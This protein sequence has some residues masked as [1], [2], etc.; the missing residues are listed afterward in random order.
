MATA[1][2]HEQLVLEIFVRDIQ[3]SSAFYRALGFE[4]VRD[5]GAFVELAFDGCLLFLEERRELP[6]PPP[7]PR[8]NVR[9]LV[10]DVDAAWARA[11]ALG[12]PVFQP[13]GDRTYGLRDFMILDPDGFGVR[14]GSRITPRGGP[15]PPA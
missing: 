13:L 7:H 2:P 5:A 14:F 3:R 6:P 8:A 9:V 15:R 4:L 10:P 1:A 12:A 11:L